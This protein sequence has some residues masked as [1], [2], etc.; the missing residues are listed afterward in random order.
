MFRIGVTFA[1]ELCHVF[2][3]YLLYDEKQHTPKA[4]SYGAEYTTDVG[5]SGRFWESQTFGGYVDMRQ[6]S[7]I[8]RVAIRHG[9]RTLSNVMIIPPSFCRTMLKRGKYSI[10]PRPQDQSTSYRQVELVLTAV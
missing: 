9:T 1:H 4:V 8:E 5:E 2:T 3:S 7:Q 10:P 6:G